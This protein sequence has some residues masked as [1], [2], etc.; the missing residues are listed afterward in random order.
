MTFILVHSPE[1]IEL[2]IQVMVKCTK[3]GNGQVYK[4][5]P[6]RPAPIS[7]KRPAREHKIYTLASVQTGN[8]SM[9][10]AI[11]QLRLALLHVEGICPVAA[12][13]ILF[14]LTRRC[15]RF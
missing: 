7:D 1:E 5:R 14:K 9:V 3:S 12:L 15:N 10:P 13:C 4:A 8:L 6:T 2:Y 11:G